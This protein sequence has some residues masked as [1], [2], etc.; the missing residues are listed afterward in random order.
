[1][2]KKI[3]AF[4]NTEQWDLDPIQMAEVLWFM[5]QVSQ[6]EQEQEQEQEEE[7][8]QEQNDSQNLISSSREQTDK[9]YNKS[10]DFPDSKIGG[11]KQPNEGISKS[12]S[13]QYPL[14]IPSSNKSQKT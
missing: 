5:H 13:S 3:I 12:S 11:S 9:N 1:M 2:L 7:Q 6:Q 8:E 4:I 14:T 10:N